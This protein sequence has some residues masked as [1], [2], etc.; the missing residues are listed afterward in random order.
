M[1]RNAPHTFTCIVD[2]GCSHSATNTFSD[3][4]PTSIRILEKPL[5]LGGIAGGLEIKYI[6]RAQWETLDDNGNVVPFNEDVL[7]HPDLPDRLLSPQSFL[8]RKRDGQKS[9]D[10]DAHFK[11]FRDRAAEWH[12]DGCRLL[13]MEYDNSFLPRMI[14]F[15][16]G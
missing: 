5:T 1:T 11:V 8:S 2:T 3:V 16:K 13:T 12:R 6:G 7:I 9:K 15:S 10:L 14:L 4:D